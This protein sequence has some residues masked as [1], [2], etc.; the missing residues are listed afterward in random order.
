MKENNVILIIDPDTPKGMWPL[1]RVIEIFCGKNER[2]IVAK[3]QIGN[4]RLKRLITKFVL[5]GFSQMNIA[6]LMGKNLIEE[7]EDVVKTLDGSRNIYLKKHYVMNIDEDYR[8]FYP[9][10]VT[11]EGK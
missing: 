6:Q 1:G 2:V 7:K 5:L 11:R 8:T 3:V 10:H 9:N 4:A